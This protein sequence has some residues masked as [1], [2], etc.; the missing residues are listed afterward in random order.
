MTR[1]KNDSIPKKNELLLQKINIISNLIKTESD[2]VEFIK[3]H[4]ID[5]YK[6]ESIVE[7]MMI[8]QL[9]DIFVRLN[10][11]QT[12]IRNRIEY[13]RQQPYRNEIN[14]IINSYEY[15]VERII[16]DDNNLNNNPI[17]INNDLIDDDDINNK[18]YDWDK[19]N[20]LVADKKETLEKELYDFR[21][22]D[23]Q[24][25][26]YFLEDR[27]I[28]EEE[29]HLINSLTHYIEILENRKITKQQNAL[30]LKLIKAQI[31]SKRIYDY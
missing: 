16:D 22:I 24:D 2:S 10:R 25:L 19:H 31:N 11:L 4:L 14:S 12:Y 1:K 26:K 13:N 3:Q 8:S 29:K 5:E 6:P 9:I 23:E 18:F 17:N 20:K 7:M 28:R 27:N 15:Q 21:K 30:K